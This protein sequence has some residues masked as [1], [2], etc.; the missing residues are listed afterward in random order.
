MNKELQIIGVDRGS[1]ILQ[2]DATAYS[3]VPLAIG[4]GS[5]SNL[6]IYGIIGNAQKTVVPAKEIAIIKTQ[7]HS[8]L[9]A[10]DAYYS[11]Y[12]LHIN[13]DILLEKQLSFENCKI[14]SENNYCIGFGSR[15]NSEIQFENC[16]LLPYGTGGCIF[17]MTWILCYFWISPITKNK[18]ALQAL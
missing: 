16:K 14:I 6:T 4:A 11:G 10:H 1:C 12:T 3:K 2:Y 15:G 5:V 17:Y 18:P 9:E 13:R 7:I 8:N